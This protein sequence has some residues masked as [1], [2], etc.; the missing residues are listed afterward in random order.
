MRLPPADRTTLVFAVALACMLFAIGSAVANGDRWT[1]LTL[2][3]SLFGFSMI[4]RAW[5]AKQAGRIR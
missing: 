4:Y 5:R 2:P 1:L 3:L